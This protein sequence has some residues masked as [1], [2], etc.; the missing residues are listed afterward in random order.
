MN[1]TDSKSSICHG[2]RQFT[3]RADVD[4]DFVAQLGDTRRAARARTRHG[5]HGASSCRE[6]RGRFYLVS[7]SR[8]L[9]T[10]QQPIRRSSRDYNL[11]R[12]VTSEAVDDDAVEHVAVRFDAEYDRVGCVAKRPRIQ[13]PRCT[14]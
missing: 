8:V 3:R 11:P 5:C 13:V 7:R 1:A 6:Q 10:V 12:S 4:V 9:A 2:R 14:R